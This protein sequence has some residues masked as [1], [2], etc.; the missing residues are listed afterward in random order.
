MNTVVNIKTTTPS[1]KRTLVIQSAANHFYGWAVTDHQTVLVTLLLNNVYRT[2]SL[3]FKCIILV[4]SN[5]VMQF[6]NLPKH[7]SSIPLLFS[8]SELE[9]KVAHVLVYHVMNSTGEWR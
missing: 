2:N 4:T 6:P 7:H 8:I 1:E 5:I 3:T 9:L